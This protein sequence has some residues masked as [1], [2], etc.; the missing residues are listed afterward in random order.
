MKSQ[1][2]QVMVIMKEQA[3]KRQKE[4]QENIKKMQ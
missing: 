4:M 2:K 1:E 3:E